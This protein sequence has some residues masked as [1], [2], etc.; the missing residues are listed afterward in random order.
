MQQC[1]RRPNNLGYMVDDVETAITWQQRH[2]G[3]SGLSNHA[4]A[5]ADVILGSSPLAERGHELGG[6]AHADAEQ[7]RPGGWN[8]T[9]AC[10]GDLA[11]APGGA[12]TERCRLALAATL[13]PLMAVL[14]QRLPRAMATYASCGKTNRPPSSIC[15]VDKAVVLDA[16]DAIVAC[17]SGSRR[18]CSRTV[19]G[20]ARSWNLT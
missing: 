7:P 6:T 19:M 18:S 11:K 20:V 8:R 1:H 2:P 5:F 13:V 10:S 16:T 3:F 15:G 4:P 12:S 14:A 9:S 17:R